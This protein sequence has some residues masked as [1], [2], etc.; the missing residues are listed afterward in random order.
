[1]DLSAA[2]VALRD[3]HFLR[4]L[5]LPALPLVWATTLWLARRRA[6]DGDWSRLIDRE[7]LAGLRLD[8]AAGGGPAPW[9][10]LL[11]AWTLAVLA[12]AG[13]S[14]QRDEAAAYRAPAAW[15]LVLDLSPS[16][17]SADVAPNRATRARYVLDDLLGAV[18]DARVAL[19]VFSDEPY[20]VAPLTQD[21]ATVRS[22]LPPLAP[23]IMP[24][25][26][27]ALA[28]ALDRAGELLQRSATR[29][30]QVVV[31]TDGFDDP[32]AAFAAAARLK[33]AGASVNVVGI[34]TRSGAPLRDAGGG[35]AQDARGDTR[36]AHLDVDRLRKLAG[37]GGGRYLDLADVPA[38]ASALQ[39]RPD[40]AER[41]RA[42][43]GVKVSHWRDA[44]VWL[45][46]GLLLIAALLARR[47][48]L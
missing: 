34:G 29:E 8:E 19:I 46:P 14:W 40:V 48:W 23:D 17:A 26:G 44:G 31:L 2:I 27:D 43:E 7:L 47:G 22:L 36:L 28:P 6:H 32:A 20:T 18:R 41:A 37:A 38:L 45:L 25:P 9:P 10:W 1:M 21:V 42:V 30:R 5:W 13:P 3:F 4:P 11:L 15:V 33:S 16:M 35:F 39:S 24:S 12:L